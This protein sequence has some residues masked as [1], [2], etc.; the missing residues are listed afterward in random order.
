MSSLEVPGLYVSGRVRARAPDP[1]RRAAVEEVERW[2]N[3]TLQMAARR[4]PGVGVVRD[5]V[6][7]SQAAGDGRL[8]YLLYKRELTR[9]LIVPRILRR[10][11]AATPAADAQL[12]TE[13]S[14]MLD[15][16]LRRRQIVRESRSFRGGWIDSTIS[17]R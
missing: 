5:P 9:R 11:F 4:I 3:D 13:L 7:F 6:A 10:F 2:A 1:E 16:Q 17:R 8:G 14:E 12:L 15:R